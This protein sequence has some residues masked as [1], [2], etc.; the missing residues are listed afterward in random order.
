M[1]SQEEGNMYYIRF[2]LTPVLAFFSFAACLATL[3]VHFIYPDMRKNICTPEPANPID[4]V[5]G[6]MVIVCH[7]FVSLY[8]ILQAFNN[9]GYW[10]G[11]S[12]ITHRREPGFEYQSSH[13]PFD[14]IKGMVG[15]LFTFGLCGY[16][17]SLC[18][19]I[20]DLCQVHNARQ[21]AEKMYI[22]FPV[23]FAFGCLGS[24]TF[25]VE[26]V[27]VKDFLVDGITDGSLSELLHVFVVFILLPYVIYSLWVV[28]VE[29]ERLADRRRL[30]PESGALAECDLLDRHMQFSVMFLLTVLPVCFSELLPM[31]WKN[32]PG[33][34]AYHFSANVAAVLFSCSGVG[35]CVA[36]LF[37]PYVKQKLQATIAARFGCEFAES[38]F[39]PEEVFPE[40]VPAS[41]LSPQKSEEDVLRMQKNRSLLSPHKTVFEQAEERAVYDVFLCL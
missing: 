18:H 20:V 2:M 15:V 33:S 32:A 37:D 5:I 23:L 29:R 6:F 3:V 40:E 34:F 9:F 10:Y 35:V 19:C 12:Y 14:T 24:S 36:R 11:P 8:I 17:C 39:V 1:V 41:E 4:N 31:L 22:V 25:V 27:G 13:I 21:R 30:H 7:M 28:Y 16:Y 38:E 26:D